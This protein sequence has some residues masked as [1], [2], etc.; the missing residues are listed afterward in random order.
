MRHLRI[1]E[2]QFLVLQAHFSWQVQH[3][4]M[5]KV[6]LVVPGATFGDVGVSLF[7]ASTACADVAVVLFVAGEIYLV[8]FGYIAG[9]LML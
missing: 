4:V 3:L 2:C 5:S 7:V 8:K 9:A 6:S 1:L